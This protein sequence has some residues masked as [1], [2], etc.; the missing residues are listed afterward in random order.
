[1]TIKEEAKQIC[2]KRR[3]MLDRQSRYPVKQN[4]G[5]YEYQRHGLSY[6]FAREL[7]G[8]ICGYADA[9]NIKITNRTLI[10]IRETCDFNEYYLL[11]IEFM[12]GRAY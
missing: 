8:Y 7:E 10:K 11:S 1:M 3:K 2:E 5:A 12:N 4:N 9:L 6:A